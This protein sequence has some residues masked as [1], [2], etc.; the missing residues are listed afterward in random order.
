VDNPLFP[1]TTRVLPLQRKRETLLDSVVSYLQRWSLWSNKQKGVVVF[2]FVDS[3][4]ALAQFRRNTSPID[5]YNFL[6]SIRYTNEVLFYQLLINN[7]V[8]MV[9]I[10][11]T[12]TVRSELYLLIN[13]SDKL[14]KSGDNTTDGQKV[15]CHCPLFILRDVHHSK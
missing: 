8:E 4:R 7:M 12:P 9:P 15:L 2:S 5:K 6:T 3:H 14:A 1:S 11:Y 13:R 10:V